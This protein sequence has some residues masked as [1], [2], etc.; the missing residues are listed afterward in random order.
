M[1]LHISEDMNLQKSYA[2]NFML[3]Q[4]NKKQKENIWGELWDLYP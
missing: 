2:D 3:R 1:L 4:E